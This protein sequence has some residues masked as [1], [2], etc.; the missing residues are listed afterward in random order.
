M[1][2]NLCGKI[3]DK[4]LGGAEYF[5]SFIDDKTRYVC[6][7]F[8]KLKHQVCEKFLESKAMVERS[9]GRKAQGY[10]HE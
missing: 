8:L 6:I 9:T 10:L 2:S 5:L 1:H 3:N 7:Y 4:S